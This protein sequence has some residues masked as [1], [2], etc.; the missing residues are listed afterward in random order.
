MSN[1]DQEDMLDIYDDVLSAPIT[2]SAIT[3]TSSDAQLSSNNNIKLTTSV[4]GNFDGG[5]DQ[6]N[7]QIN[8]KLNDS[9]YE[10]DSHATPSIKINNLQWW[11][12]DVFMENI[13]QKFGA[14][15]TLKFEEEKNNGKSK[16]V[17]NC[18]FEDK[19]QAMKAKETL[20]G[21]NIHDNIIQVE[22]ISKIPTS[23]YSVN[24]QQQNR[25]QDYNSGDM[26]DGDDHEFSGTSSHTSS[27]G[28]NVSNQQQASQ[29]D[30]YSGRGS[31]SDTYDDRQS[32]NKGYYGGGG[33]SGSSR[34][35]M[36]G[37]RSSYR[38]GDTNRGSGD[39]YRSSSSS[40]SYN[41]DKK[42]DRKN[43]E[44]NTGDGG[45]RDRSS[46]DSHSSR[47][48]KSPRRYGKSQYY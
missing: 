46:Y 3:S 5:F 43:Y 45:R 9:T 14:I 6:I 36:S 48:Q 22:Y 25:R 40:S 26:N 1:N 2:A 34:S 13:L 32:G 7:S 44:T 16:G 39:Y 15:K 19:F 24:T 47:S 35:S 10:D 28:S 37:D 38:G 29:Q 8:D 30:Y 42:R 18:E 20:N 11:T 27:I 33:Q 17:L 41:A 31:S 4:V 21:M 12:T 23:R